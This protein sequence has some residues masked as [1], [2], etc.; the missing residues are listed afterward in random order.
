MVIVGTMSSAEAVRL[1]RAAIVSCLEK[2][3]E[4][5]RNRHTGTGNIHDHPLLIAGAGWISAMQTRVDGR[6]SR[7]VKVTHPDTLIQLEMDL[8]SGQ[9]AG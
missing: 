1:A 8:D 2:N 4:S 5:R 7:L 9:Q 3:G 6:M